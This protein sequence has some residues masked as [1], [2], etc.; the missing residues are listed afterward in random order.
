MAAGGSAD[1]MIA[2]GAAARQD[3]RPRLCA[4]QDVVMIRLGARRD[5]PDS[6]RLE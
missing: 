6:P 5:R 4:G 2:G 3:F 1:V